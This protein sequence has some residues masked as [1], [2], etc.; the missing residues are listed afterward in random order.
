MCRQT[1][2]DNMLHADESNGNLMTEPNRTEPSQPQQAPQTPDAPINPYANGNN[3]F[4][5]RKPEATAQD[6]S[7]QLDPVMQN[8]PQQSIQTSNDAPHQQSPDPAGMLQQPVQREAQDQQPETV[9]ISGSSKAIWFVGGMLLGLIGMLIL[10]LINF[11]K[12]KAIR[13]QIIKYAAIG[14]LVGFVIN[15]IVLSMGGFATG[16]DLTWPM[17]GGSLGSSSGTGSGIF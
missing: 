17:T 12:P 2:N 16:T 4:I 7:Q 1:R 11:R 13:N 5:E 14:M 10:Y 9:Q 6:L 15:L 8:A 3:P